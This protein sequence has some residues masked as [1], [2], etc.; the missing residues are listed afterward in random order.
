MDIDI[1]LTA[2]WLG[3]TNI[4]VDVS[5]INNE[6]STYDGRIRVYVTEIQSSM[7]WTDT[8]GYPYTFPL[9]DFA[10]NEDISISAG[11]TWTG[12]T[13]W[14]GNDHGYSGITEDNLMIIA[15]VFNDE[16]HQGYAYPPDENPFDAYYVD[17]TAGFRIG[18]NRQPN[19]PDIDGLAS[20][21]AGD[22]YNYTFSASD[23]DW[24][25]ELYYY[26]DWGDGNIEEWIG[27]YYTTDE[28]MLSH[29]WEDQ[30][31][32]IITAKVK[33]DSDVESEETTLEVTMPKNKTFIQNN[34]FTFLEKNPNL[35]PLLRQILGI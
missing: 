23:P 35:F 9:L 22:E 20:G 24:F 19:A 26:I 28:I 12:S 3:G 34:F 18:N 6:A 8:W 30:E 17:E 11:G 27:P 33:D 7:G 10:F 4:L 2:S 29:T 15:A 31:T 21:N 32:Y 25:D 1:A 13:N 5:V 14:I 16:W